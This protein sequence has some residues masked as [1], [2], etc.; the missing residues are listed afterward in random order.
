MIYLKSP[1]EIERMRRA[2]RLLAS[3]FMKIAGLIK[4]GGITADIDAY[5]EKLIID[6]GGEPAFKGYK[7]GG[8]RKFPA[9]LCMSV[10]NEIVHGI[11]SKRELKSGQIVGVDAGVKLDGWYADMAGSFLIDEVNDQ[12]KKLWNVTREALYRGIKQMR[13]G[14]RLSEIGSAI[15]NWVESNG[16][17]VIRD[18]VGHGIGTNLHEDPAVPNYN[19]R[20]GDLT[21]KEG[22]TLAVEPMVSTGSYKIKVLSDGWT[23]VTVDD[24]PTA[25]F[26]HTILITDSEPEILTLADDDKDPWFEIGI[27]TK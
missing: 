17:S 13:P 19:F 8:S 25:H 22:M 26:E 21:L 2:G 14:N 1:S 16:F 15:Q 3:V 24:S 10:D 7:G 18:L 27:N 4:P 12:K 5:A 9:T 20:R 11:P 6:A 23:A